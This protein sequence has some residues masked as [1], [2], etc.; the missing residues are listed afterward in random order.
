M[1]GRK[2]VLMATDTYKYFTVGPLSHTH[3]CLEITYAGVDV[4]SES[5]WF[6]VGLFVVSHLHMCASFLSLSHTLDPS[7]RLP[8]ETTWSQSVRARG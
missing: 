8:T 6:S 5:L 2:H 1:H 7:R 4:R 3:V